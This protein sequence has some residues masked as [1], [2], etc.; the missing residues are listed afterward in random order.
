M[1]ILSMSSAAAGVMD[2]KVAAQSRI[3]TAFIAFS[4]LRRIAQLL[5]RNDQAFFGMCDN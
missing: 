4:P 3:E 1:A 5:N 2:V